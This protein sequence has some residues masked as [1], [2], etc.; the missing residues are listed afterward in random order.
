MASFLDEP[1]EVT[2][3]WVGYRLKEFGFQRRRTGGKRLYPMSARRVQDVLARY[4][5]EAP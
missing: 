2:S 1:G 4:A 5:V 3:Q